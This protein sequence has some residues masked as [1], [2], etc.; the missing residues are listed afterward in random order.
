MFNNYSGTFAAAISMFVI[1]MLA[2]W[3]FS[4]GCSNEL[5]NIG[6]P[7]VVAGVLIAFRYAKGGVT[8]VGTRV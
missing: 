5:V 7:A 8:L 1:P 6:V 4:E 2:Q 3:G